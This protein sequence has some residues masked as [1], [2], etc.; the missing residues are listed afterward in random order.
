MAILSAEQST[1]Y[2]FCLY[3]HSEFENQPPADSIRKW[4][5][6]VMAEG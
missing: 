6:E 2:P 4:V 3:T 5:A 1:L